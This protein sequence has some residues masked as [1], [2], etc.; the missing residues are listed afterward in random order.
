MSNSDFAENTQNTQDQPDQQQQGRG[1]DYGLGEE[2]AQSGKLNEGYGQ[3]EQMG[4]DQWTAQPA[5]QLRGTTNDQPNTPDAEGLDNM[6]GGMFG[7]NEQGQ[8]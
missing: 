8:Q 7:D 2:Y 4:E 6:A 3:S 1:A 5:E